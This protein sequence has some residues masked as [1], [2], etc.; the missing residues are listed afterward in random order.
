LPVHFFRKTGYTL[1]MGVGDIFDAARLKLEDIFDKTRRAVAGSAGPVSFIVQKRTKVSVLFG[2]AGG[3]V[4]ILLI[5]VTTV[6]LNKA[7]EKKAEARGTR[8]MFSVERIPGDEF[9][10]PDEPDFLPPV[11]LYRE[12]KE[13]WT[14]KDAAPFWT[15]PATLDD[16]WRSNVTEYIDRLLE[17]VP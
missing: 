3:V 9:F 12:Q 11:L 7:G 4:F 5:V 17:S 8:E 13:R 14:D 6:V 1:R 2:L 16:D 15:D 10:L